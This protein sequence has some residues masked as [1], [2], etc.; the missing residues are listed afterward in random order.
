MDG[1]T[2]QRLHEVFSSFSNSPEGIDGTRFAKLC[3]NL[4]YELSCLRGI[5]ILEKCIFDIVFANT[6]TIGRRRL[7]YNQFLL[8]LS[9]LSIKFGVPIED[10]IRTICGFSGETT[11]RV[12]GMYGPSRFYYD[13]STYTGTASQ[14]ASVS[15]PNR[16]IDLSEIVNRAKPNESLGSPTP[17][18]LTRSSVNRAKLEDALGSRTPVGII[19]SSVKKYSEALTAPNSN[20]ATPSPRTPKSTFIEQVM[21]LPSVDSYFDGFLKPLDNN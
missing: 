17:V 18:A 12:S 19:P 14:K 11:K 15:L 21:C 1:G 3:R 16:I 13:K 20:F 7:D 10:V 8:A 6:K 4:N 5:P 9:K 2:A